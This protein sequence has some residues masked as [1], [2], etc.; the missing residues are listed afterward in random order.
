MS[1]SLVEKYPLGEHLSDVL[2]ADSGRPLTD[3]T[4]EAVGQDQLTAQDLRIQAETLQAQ[5]EIARQAGYHQLA[6]N[7]SRA[8]ELTRVPNA[9][10]LQIYEALRPGRATYADVVAIA[11]RLEERY[12]ALLT[13]QFVHEAALV[14]RKRGLLKQEAE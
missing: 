2:K 8:A 13:A 9:E 11:E 6:V 10:L 3:L 1:D 4:L 14:Y 7:L 5:A 12:N